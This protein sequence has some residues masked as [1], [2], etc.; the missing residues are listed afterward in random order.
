VDS[1]C[2]GLLPMLQA[3]AQA[4]NENESTKFFVIADTAAERVRSL[5]REFSLEQA[6]FIIAP[7]DESRA[8]AAAD[9]ILDLNG[10]PS[11]SF[12]PVAA[13]SAG[14]LSLTALLHGR[15]LVAADVPSNRDLTPQGRGCLWYK[16]ADNSGGDNRELAHSLA[17]LARNRDFRK[18]LGDSGRKHII[19]TRA[20]QRIGQRYTEVYGHAH[21][22]RRHHSDP[23]NTSASLI[24]TRACL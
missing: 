14:R 20:P 21:E 15:A 10:E 4:H 2:V 1:A 23:Q 6:L 24:P 12:Q 18:V 3:F 13:F 7:V 9:I 11:Q 17:F 22:R 8:L 19:D 5:A 16:P